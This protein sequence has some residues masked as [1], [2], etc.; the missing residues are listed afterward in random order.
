MQ[1]SLR[2]SIETERRAAA[3][4]LRIHNALD[5]ASTNMM[6]ADNEGRIIYMN[7]A[8]S[9]MMRAAEADIR[10]DLPNFRAEGLVGRNF[11][12]FHKNPAH[13]R[14]LLGSLKGVHTAQIQIGG[15]TFKLVANP[16]MN[17][18]GERLGSVVEWADRTGEV[19]AENELEG[20][21]GA[22]VRGDF[23]HRL[24]LSGKNGFFKKLAEGMNQLVTTVSDS[25]S[26]IA[27]V[28]KAVAAGDLTR[29]STATTPAP[30]VN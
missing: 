4:T 9:E 20:L 3:E 25:L 21:L 2:E 26:Q 28:L 30:S 24:E 29:R 10:K 5:K 22:V 19:H 12:E 13:Q 16:V 23:T 14:N 18:Q 8:V 1:T 11:D 7:E 27:G 17:E 15:R 6:V